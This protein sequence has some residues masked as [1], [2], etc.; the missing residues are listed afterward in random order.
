MQQVL[1]ML[2]L[3][4]HCSSSY[5][6]F[7]CRALVWCTCQ[8][9]ICNGCVKAQMQPDIS[10]ALFS[11]QSAKTNTLVRCSGLYRSA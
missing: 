10:Y 4:L 5:M 3:S 2:C 11:A 9:A 7:L 1:M 6:V 8:M